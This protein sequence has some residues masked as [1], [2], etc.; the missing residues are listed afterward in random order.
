MEKAGKE[1]K[2]R[3]R[4]IDFLLFWSIQNREMEWYWEEMYV[5]TRNKEIYLGYW[6]DRVR[7]RGC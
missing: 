5:I 2:T 1:R 7:L 4:E 3:D 6:S